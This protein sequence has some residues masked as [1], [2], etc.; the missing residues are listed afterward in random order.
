MNRPVNVRVILFTIM[1]I[2]AVMLDK[3]NFPCYNRI[4]KEEMIMKKI[5]AALGIAAILPVAI[6]AGGC[7]GAAVQEIEVQIKELWQDYTGTV[8]GDF[9]L[10]QEPSEEFVFDV[11][12]DGG[13]SWLGDGKGASF[14][15]TVQNGPAVLIGLEQLQSFGVETSAP[16]NVAVRV[17]GN[18]NYLAGKTSNALSFSLRSV[19][20][21]VTYGD[22]ARLSYIS[23]SYQ[24]DIGSGYRFEEREGTYYLKAF[25]CEKEEDDGNGERWNVVN[26]A[27]PA[28]LVFEYRYLDTYH[29]VD[30]VLEAESDVDFNRN[31]GWTEYDPAR[32]ISADEY[33]AKLVARE[34]TV[35]GDGDAAGSTVLKYICIAVRAK[36][37]DGK[38]QSAASIANILVDEGN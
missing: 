22:F 14:T 15:G 6:F 24:F 11:S 29:G 13:A 8:R 34:E 16:L 20:S 32:G 27:L 26:S 31:A 12:V 33:T 5:T 35:T 7:G 21:D 19:L 30:T 23:D 9:L 38:L 17:A 2:F 25:T 4:D 3:D 18:G 28:G 36:A 10:S 37:T 1:C